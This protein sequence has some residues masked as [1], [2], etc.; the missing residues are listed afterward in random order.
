VVIAEAGTP[1]PQYSWSLLRAEIFVDLF[2]NTSS[3]K[4]RADAALR[5]FRQARL[6]QT[7]RLSQPP[8]RSAKFIPDDVI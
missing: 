5:S 6:R 7:Q 2:S 3:V 1:L 8:D 4:S